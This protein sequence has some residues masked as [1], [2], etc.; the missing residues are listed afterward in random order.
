[1]R[2]DV[3]SLFPAM[4]DG[5]WGDS[6]LRIAREKKLLDARAHDL[7]VW[8][9]DKHGKVD[10]K[11]CGGGPGMVIRCQPVVDAVR[12][13]RAMTNPPGRLLFLG[14]DGRRFDQ[15]CARELAAE[16]RLLLVCGRYEG[17]D[18][19]IFELL[20]PEILSVGDYVLSGGE[21]PAMVVIDAVTRLIPGVLGSEESLDH[22]SFNPHADPDART[23]QPVQRLLDYPQYTQPAVYEGLEVPEVL[24]G[25]NHALIR[26]WRYETAL[27]RTREQRPDLLDE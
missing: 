21:I 9:T 23:D 15:N 3:L 17:F 13:V 10:D 27:R 20:K 5:V 4:F 14:P 19:R 2:I 22:E 26:K 24:R 8:T 6:I 1:M 11:P 18:Q 7:R 25:G 16:P 12:A